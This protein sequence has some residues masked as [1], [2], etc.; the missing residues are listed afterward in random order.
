[1]DTLFVCGEL[2]FHVGSGYLLKTKETFWH[3]LTCTR[4]SNN[5][6]N[7]CHCFDW[8]ERNF[9]FRRT[10][11]ISDYTGQRPPKAE[12]QLCRFIVFFVSVCSF[13]FFL[14]LPH[15]TRCIVLLKAVVKDVTFRANALC[16][17]ELMPAWS[18]LKVIFKA[19]VLPTL[20]YYL[21]IIWRKE[22]IPH[23]IQNEI[24]DWA[25]LGGKGLTNVRFL[26]KILNLCRKC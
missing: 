16:Q 22:I 5:N 25:S 11:M 19:C 4:E 15:P 14:K 10:I 20:K 21:S 7:N 17:R 18:K 8:S 23:H 9:A 6:N 12:D 3:P 1:M 2:F 24:K 26:G 13:G